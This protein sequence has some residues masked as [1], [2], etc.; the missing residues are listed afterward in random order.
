MS[1]YEDRKQAKIDRYNELSEKNQEKSNQAYKDSKDMVSCIPMG[2]PILV[3]HHSEKGHR[4][5]LNRSWNKMGKSVEL[6]DKSNYYK[7][8]AEAAE[9]NTAISS[10]D[11]E[12]LTKLREK[13]AGLEKS[14][15]L[16][17]DANKI[18]KSK[19]LNEV[20]KVE[21][22]TGIGYT[23]E[24]AFEVM[25]PN[26]MGRV[27]FA[28]YSLTNNNANM[29]TVKKRIEILEA[30]QGMETTETVINGI[31]IVSNI[32]DNRVQIFFEDKP[33]EEVRTDL[34]KRY[35]FKWSRYNE[36]W[37][38]HLNRWAVDQAVEVVKKHYTE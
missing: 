28:S 31:R 3:G 33:S 35:G 2:Q 10:D 14:Q 11:P 6:Q 8:K 36:C 16:M 34:K 17:K 4:S 24:Q 32:E 29:K 21:A 12:A 22:L 26:F 1:N 23:Q 5:L 9:N 18:I 37:Q 19:K 13:L 15:Q 25:K 20:Q 30:R 38:R 7:G 27:G